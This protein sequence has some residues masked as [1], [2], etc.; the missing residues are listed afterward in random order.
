MSFE[1][2]IAE[3]LPRL[4]RYA[5]ALLR[6]PA[7]ADDL[8][9][10]CVERALGKKH[11]FKP[12]TDLRAWLFT[13][14]HNV[15]V[16]LARKRMRTAN[17]VSL[18]QAGEQAGERAGERAGDLPV[19]PPSQEDALSVRDLAWALEQLPD[20]QRQAVLLVG[21]EGLSY[22]ETAEVLAAPV[23]TVMSRL[24]RGREKLRALLDGNG[25]PQLRRV[26]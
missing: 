9:Q 18:E 7:A 2:G 11:L 20:D 14:M 17:T 19:T 8:V 1:D 12:G 22:K 23:G 24:A 3:H 6:D 13:V 21:L 4:R 25:A 10:S 16:N 26:K 15:H 5:R